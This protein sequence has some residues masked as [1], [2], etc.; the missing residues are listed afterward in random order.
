VH[1]RQSV[2]PGAFEPVEKSLPSK[3]WERQ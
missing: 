3:E 1:E 2:T